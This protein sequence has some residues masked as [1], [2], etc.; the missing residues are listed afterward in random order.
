M[1]MLM[2]SGCSRL[3]NAPTG[4]MGRVHKVE[5]LIGAMFQ[6]E[7]QN[8]RILFAPKISTSSEA[9]NRELQACSPAPAP[10]PVPALVKGKMRASELGAHVI[11]M[12]A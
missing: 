2:I 7:R 8:S 1:L 4:N 6:Y 9:L 12:G 11:K 5:L 3:F 10:V